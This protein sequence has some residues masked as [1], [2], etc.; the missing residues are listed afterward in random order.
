MSASEPNVERLREMARAVREQLPEGVFYCLIIWPPG[1]PDDVGYFS[2][3]HRAEAFVALETIR[4]H[5][6]AP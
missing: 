5:D 3:A 2:N 6:L 4:G 1:Q